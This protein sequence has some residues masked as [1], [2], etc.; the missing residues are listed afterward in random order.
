MACPRIFKRKR[1][2][3]LL[4]FVVASLMSGCGGRAAERVAGDGDGDGGGEGGSPSP[5]GGAI[6][7]GDGDLGGSTSTGGTAVS[8]GGASFSTGGTATAGTGGE[9]E[10]SGGSGAG[11]EAETG[12]SGGVSGSGGSI[13]EVT[14]LEEFGAECSVPGALSCSATEPRL[15]LICDAD[16][17]WVSNGTCDGDSLCD[18]S[19]ENRG[20]C[21]IP[22]PHCDGEE[23]GHVY[24]EGTQTFECGERATF[25]NEVGAC[26]LGCLDGVCQ[27]VTDACPE[28]TS[29]CS[30][31][32]GGKVNCNQGSVCSGVMNY[33]P[34]WPPAARIPAADELCPTDVAGCELG[35]PVGIVLGP[36]S[37]MRMIVPEDWSALLVTLSQAND[38]FLEDNCVAPR[39]ASC[40]SYSGLSD[41]ATVLLFPS[42]PDAVARNIVVEF[43]DVPLECP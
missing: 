3:S 8:T 28:P 2:F 36:H 31:D 27:P 23:P 4:F 34:L 16:H 41:G 43:S 18:P 30:S 33:D 37:N 12:G 7:D 22:L 20:S 25:S 6:G 13:S 5:S 9:P 39:E 1:N 14:G 42:R 24:C 40:I 17:N 10:T 21:Q 32:C 38:L 19:L 35:S 29:S 11:G 26:S 15:R